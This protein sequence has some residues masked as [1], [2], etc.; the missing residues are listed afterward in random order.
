MGKSKTFELLNRAESCLVHATVKVNDKEIQ[1]VP[2]KVYLP[3]RTHEKPYLIFKPSKYDA[4]RIAYS[5]KVGFNAN[6][7]DSNHELQTSMFASE[8][9]FSENSTK[10]WGSDVSEST[11]L[12]TPQD[13]HVIDHLKNHDKPDKTNVEL[14]ISPN[15][16]I[17]PFI[18]Q[19]TSY[20]GEIT[21]E[22]V[23]EC[24]F[25]IK[26]GTI[27]KFDKRFKYKTS[28]NKD[29]VQWSYLVGCIEVEMVAIELVTIKDD[30]LQE[31]DDF[32]LLVSL[33]TRTRTACLGWTA[34]DKN[35]IT[36]FYR[37]KYSFP[38][39]HKEIDFN[40]VVVDIEEFPNFIECCYPTFQN[41]K[42]KLALRNTLYSAIPSQ[43]HS[44]ETSYLSL[45]AGLETLILDFRRTEN[46]ELILP[47]VKFKQ[48]RKY[49]KECVKQAPKPELT[50]AQQ[51]L[52]SDK[53]GELNRISL[54]EAFDKFCEK[55]TIDLS[56]LWPVFGG[57][58]VPGLV[59]IRNKLIHGDPLAHNVFGALIVAKAH[60]NYT[61]ERVLI[62]VLG[63][64]VGRTKVCTSFLAA[65]G[66]GMKDL[67][68]EQQKLSEYILR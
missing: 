62:R 39:I 35:S 54:R 21:Q 15:S 11:V 3:E 49:L 41:Y 9:Y 63:W 33:A 52:I 18:I 48:L 30:L 68:A 2:C 44:I 61:L 64:E 55:Y 24:Q 10:Y 20:T 5:Y 28:N 7:S 16:F 32:L 34:H 45:F 27:L 13:L 66:I 51:E 37:G 1:N 67:Q 19:T 50:P 14:W 22:R 47:Q 56:D 4:A 58:G 65:N 42:N 6:I 25:V 26:D 8:V 57:N 38:D 40:D 46:M 43:P 29:L 12:G 53:L 36:K 31:I 60:L 59:D 23:N 17:T